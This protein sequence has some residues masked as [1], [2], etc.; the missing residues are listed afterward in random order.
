MGK[1]KALPYSGLPTNT[2][3]IELKSWWMLMLLCE[4]LMNNRLLT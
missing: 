1:E 4:S 3:I 2:K